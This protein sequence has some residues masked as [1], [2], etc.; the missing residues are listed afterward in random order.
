MTGRASGIIRT[1]PSLYGDASAGARRYRSSIEQL[2]RG[3][4]P[5]IYIAL[6]C[7]PRLPVLHIYLVVEGHIDVRL[8]IA[9]YESGDARKCWDR[10]IRQPKVWVVC[11]APV[12]RPPEPI[13]FRGFQGIRYTEDLW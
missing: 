8:N 7:V 12:V 11:T 5:A 9:D 1:L 4:I 10:T 13:A 3:R 6:P 2:E